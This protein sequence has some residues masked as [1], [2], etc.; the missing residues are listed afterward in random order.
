MDTNGALKSLLFCFSDSLGE[1][2]H[3]DRLKKMDW[4]LA[5]LCFICKTEVESTNY[6]LIR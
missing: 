3:L 6:I 5:R 1:N 4:P 2:S